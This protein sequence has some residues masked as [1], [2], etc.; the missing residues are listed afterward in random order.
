[1]IKNINK[2]GPRWGLSYVYR[3]WYTVGE[4]CLLF[5]EYA[6]QRTIKIPL[7]ASE[8]SIARI[9]FQRADGNTVAT[10]RNCETRTQFSL[11]P[12]YQVCMAPAR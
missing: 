7:V 2:R 1:M 5:E 9:E 10:D 6:D 4:K 12:D 11:K 3:S 8:L